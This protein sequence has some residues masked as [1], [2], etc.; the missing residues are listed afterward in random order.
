MNEPVDT[1]PRIRCRVAMG[2]LPVIGGGMVG[3]GGELKRALGGAHARV[4]VV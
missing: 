2:S 4:G 1:V 3:Y